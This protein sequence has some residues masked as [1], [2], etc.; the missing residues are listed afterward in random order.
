MLK[1]N[2]IE[3]YLK[4]KYSIFFA[5]YD[6]SEANFSKFFQLIHRYKKVDIYSDKIPYPLKI[7]DPSKQLD[8]FAI[9]EQWRNRQMTNFDYLCCLNILSGRSNCDLNQYF[10]F[11][12]ILSDYR[13]SKCK[14]D[15]S[16]YRDLQKNMGSLGSSQ[17][18]Q[19]FIDIKNN[20]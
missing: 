1:Q 13:T 17:R 4:E 9:T 14:K 8:R 12:W 2:S 19:K 11:P 10:I 16:K 7:I 6:K 5:F 15:Q 20:I 3:F 18:I